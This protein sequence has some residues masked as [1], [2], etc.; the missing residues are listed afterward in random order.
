M[1]KLAVLQTARLFGQVLQSGRH[2]TLTV[3]HIPGELISDAAAFES[4]R[5]LLGV[6]LRPT[7]E[8]MREFGK[9]VSVPDLCSAKL[10]RKDKAWIDPAIR[11]DGNPES[12][13]LYYVSLKQLLAPQDEECHHGSLDAMWSE[14]RC[15]CSLD[16]RV[17][18][19]SGVGSGLV[20]GGSGR[21]RCW[22]G[23]VPEGFGAVLVLVPECSEML[24]CGSGA[25]SGRVPEG[26]GVGS[27]MLRCGSSVGSGGFREV[28][29]ARQE[30]EAK[31]DMLWEK[32]WDRI[33]EDEESLLVASC[34]TGLQPRADYANVRAVFQQWDSTGRGTLQKEELLSI[35]SSIG[36]TDR[37]LAVV[38]QT[39][40]IFQDQRVQSVQYSQFLH[41]VFGSGVSSELSVMPLQ[42]RGCE[43]EVEVD[44]AR[45]EQEAKEDMLWEKLWDR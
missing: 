22:F 13:V 2:S 28:D 44:K 41:W 25:G 31:E 18:E 3:R 36:I 30:Q 14:S 4:L 21:F 16:M 19:G 10:L 40:D 17:P 12:G 38:L 26:S 34:D 45:Q 39:A 23:L 29:K 20:P 5:V 35:L 6:P 24:R 7:Y 42:G 37:E 32:L 33:D 9:D 43:E 11:F 15:C 8:P 1:P 27:G